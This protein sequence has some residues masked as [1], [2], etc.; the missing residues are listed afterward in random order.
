M[1]KKYRV[2]LPFLLF[3]YFIILTL[4]L[5][6]ILLFLD[7]VF[8]PAFNFKLYALLWSSIIITLVMPYGLQIIHTISLDTSG[9]LIFKSL[10]FQKAYESKDLMLITTNFGEGYFLNFEFRRVN[11]AVLNDVHNLSELITTIR[12]FNSA[13]RTIGFRC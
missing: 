3:N 1:S 11:I 6:A 8:N 12:S 5:V 2:A 9:Q 7:V 13:V 4:S 10:M